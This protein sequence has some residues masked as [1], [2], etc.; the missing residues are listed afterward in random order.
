M[1]FLMEIVNDNFYFIM[2]ST[3]STLS[4]RC[5]RSPHLKVR[6]LSSIFS[7]P[8]SLSGRLKCQSTVRWL[9]NVNFANMKLNL[10]TKS[11]V[12]NRMALLKMLKNSLFSSV[13]LNLKNC[14]HYAQEQAAA[15][16][17]TAMGKIDLK[18][19][20]LKAGAASPRSAE[21]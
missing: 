5:F 21:T 19:G 14:Y 10:T 11:Y 6:S 12:L 2:Y 9:K 13:N 16:L 3:I 20:R 1:G 18:V 15:I 8:D 4:E 7:R 17:K